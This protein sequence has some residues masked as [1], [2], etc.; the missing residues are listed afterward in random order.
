MQP[1]CDL[2]GGMPELIPPP[3]HPSHQ[4][5]THSK[6]HDADAVEVSG[7]SSERAAAGNKTFYTNPLN[8]FP[9]QSLNSFT[10]IHI[11]VISVVYWVQEVSLKHKDN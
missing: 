6:F 11:Y 2:L 3:I 8:L 10:P 4:R 1:H 5:I 9:I 7:E